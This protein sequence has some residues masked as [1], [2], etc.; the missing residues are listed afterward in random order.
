MGGMG[1]MVGRCCATSN[2]H[3]PV[4]VESEVVCGSALTLAP[5]P[6]IMG[7]TLAWK[8]RTKT[9]GE[10]LA[11]NRTQKGQDTMS[12][13]PGCYLVGEKRRG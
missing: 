6:S 3:L 11:G 8:M 5:L 1:G 10:F 12:R 4:P 7:T 9:K 13:S 2:C